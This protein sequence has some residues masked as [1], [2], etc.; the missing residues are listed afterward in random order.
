MYDW[1]LSICCGSFINKL[2]E[3]CGVCFPTKFGSG[4]EDS[5]LV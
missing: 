1:P 5:R 2:E 4:V 3:M